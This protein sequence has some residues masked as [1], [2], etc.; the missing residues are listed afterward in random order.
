MSIVSVCVVVDSIYPQSLD[1]MV[2]VIGMKYNTTGYTLALEAYY[3]IMH[4]VAAF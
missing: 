4:Y 2:A 1:G 3:I